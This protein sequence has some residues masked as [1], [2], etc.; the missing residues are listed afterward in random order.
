METKFTKGNWVQSALGLAVMLNDKFD[1]ACIADCTNIRQNDKDGTIPLEE[2]E[3]NARLIA[4]APAMYQALKALKKDF[5]CLCNNPDSWDSL[6]VAAVV[7]AAID[8]WK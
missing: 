1:G 2:C 7:L 4:N 6:K 3:A 5:E 8:G